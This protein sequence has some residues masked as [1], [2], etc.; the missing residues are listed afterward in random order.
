[1]D[2]RSRA[3]FAREPPPQCR[4]IC[5][6]RPWLVDRQAFVLTRLTLYSV[7]AAVKPSMLESVLL[8]DLLNL[9]SLP[10]STVSRPFPGNATSELLDRPGY[11]KPS[12]QH[13]PKLSLM[14]AQPRLPTWPLD[15]QVPIWAARGARK[16]SKQQS[17][18]I[19]TRNFERFIRSLGSGQIAIF[20]GYTND[21]TPEPFRF[22]S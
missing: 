21:A 10:Q 22:P 7:G 12:L 3:A 11:W 2:R 20:L 15:V 14:L 16:A 18:W 4:T 1:M 6:D 8:K 13:Q 9:S 17:S 5:N 19:L